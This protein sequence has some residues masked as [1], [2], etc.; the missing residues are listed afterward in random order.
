MTASIL[1]CVVSDVHWPHH[2]A[3]AYAAWREWHATVRP[4][5]TICLGDM[6]DLA[7][8]SRYDKDGS[9]ALPSTEIALAARELNAIASEAQRVT[10][11]V[12]NHEDRFRRL[13]SGIPAHVLEGLHGLTLRDQ[14]RAHGLSDRVEWWTESTATP[15]LEV[16]QFRLRHGHKQAGRFG[17]G[18]NPASN[19]VAKS[20]GVSELFGHHHVAQTTARAAH[21]RVVQ[22]I[23]N[24]CME[25]MQPYA[26]SDQ[27]WPLGFTVLE[28]FPGWQWATAHPVVMDPRGC[29]AWGG[30]VYGVEDARAEAKRQDNARTQARAKAKGKAAK[31]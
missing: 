19:R 14:L 16:A 13:L 1:V 31:R 24:P 7:A 27:T 2:H 21:G 22:A 3:T 23:A 30:R 17:G 26:G 15:S 29:F 4:Y 18:V 5:W 28:V 11:A 9:E 25:A 12:G 6:I 8:M 10:F 20:L